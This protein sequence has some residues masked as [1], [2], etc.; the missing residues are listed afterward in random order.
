MSSTRRYNI[1]QQE[2]FHRQ[3]TILWKNLYT[4]NYTLHQCHQEDWP[5]MLGRLNAAID[6]VQGGELFSV[7]HTDVRDGVPNANSR[8]YAACILESLSHLH[9]RHISYRDLKLENIKDPLDASHFDSYAHVENEA[10]QFYGI[11]I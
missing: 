11:T 3:A 9:L 1:E 2:V 4:F 8:F 6:L 5:R 7:I 10:N